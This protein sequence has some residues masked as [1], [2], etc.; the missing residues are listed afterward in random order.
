MPD[1]TVDLITNYRFV[2]PTYRHPTGGAWWPINES[3]AVARMTQWLAQRAEALT[4]VAVQC[5]QA[6]HTHFH[7]GSGRATQ[8]C[9]PETRRCEVHAQAARSEVQTT[10]RTLLI[11]EF[12]CWLNLTPAGATTVAGPDSL[13]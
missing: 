2:E 1:E 9:S 3:A 6:G 11:K 5:A 12:V 13:G 7:A 10:T 8:Q 4:L